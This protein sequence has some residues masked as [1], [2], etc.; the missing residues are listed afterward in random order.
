MLNTF[1]QRYFP[2][3]DALLRQ[4]VDS[5]PVETPDYG[6]MLRYPLGWVDANNQPHQ[7]PTGKRIRPLLLLLCCEAA[8]GDWQQALPA[9]AAVELLHNFSLIHDD[10]QDD[11]P[12]R[13]NRPTVWKVW[14]IANGINAGDAMFTL[15]YVALAHLIERGVAPE[16]VFACWQNFNGTAIELTRGQHLDMRYERQPIVSVEDYITMISGKTAALVACCAQ[17]GALIA[18]GDELIA[19]YYASFGLNLGIAFQIRDDILGI[20]GEPDVTGK[21]AAT[22]I[23]TRK[24]SL[25]V[26]H[27]LQHNVDLRAIY[28][29]PSLNDADVQ[30]V[31]ALLD[32]TDTLG[33]T[34]QQE[35]KFYQRAIDALTNANPQGTAAQGLTA[36]IEMLF[37]RAN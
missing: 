3:L 13:H 33:Y 29:Q 23:L 34:R 37:Q 35:A 25:P 1:S 28:A 22:D 9:A 32:A 36:L 24:K 10:I 19:S 21:S 18:S 2:S 12:T 7:Q 16:G 5:A 14:G 20:W 17:L 11:S 30:H 31:I 26:L 8:G 27:G 6:V 15:A 4:I